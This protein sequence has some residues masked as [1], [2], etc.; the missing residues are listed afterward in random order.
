MKRKLVINLPLPETELARMVD[1]RLIRKSG[2]DIS[3]Q[4]NMIEPDKAIH[5]LTL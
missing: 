3:V 1:T 2:T 5:K 4:I